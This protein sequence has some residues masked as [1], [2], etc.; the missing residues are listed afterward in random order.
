[1]EQGPT[2][3]GPFFSRRFVTWRR[4]LR[5]DRRSG[6]G[7]EADDSKI[8]RRWDEEKRFRLSSERSP[9]GHTQEPSGRNIGTDPLWTQKDRLGVR[10]FTV[11]KICSY[12]CF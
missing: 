11:G 8:R 3:A 9:S 1:M 7:D 10:I 2:L 5:P 4:A 12:V 6:D